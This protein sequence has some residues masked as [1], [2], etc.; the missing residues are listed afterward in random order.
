MNADPSLLVLDPARALAL[1]LPRLDGAVRRMT[2]RGLLALSGGTVSID[3][4]RRLAEAPRPAIFALTHH[5]AW[6]AVLAPAALIALRGGRRVRFLVDWM[7]VDLPWTG[8]LVRQIDPIRVDSKRALFGLRAPRRGSVRRAP[9]FDAALAA[10]RAGDDVGVY[11]E[12][13]RNRDPWRLGE[14]RRG[15][16]CLALRSGVPVVPVG[17]DFPAR[18]RILRT[19]RAGRFVLRVGEPLEFGAEH[20]RWL[21]ADGE[22]ERR[23]VEREA[24]GAIL[25]RVQREL[26]SLARKIFVAPA[27]ST[28]RSPAP[29]IEEPRRLVVERVDDADRRRA[30]LGVV[31]E[32]YQ[33]EKGWIPEAA[34]EIPDD[35]AA[36]SGV[37]WLLARLG[38]EPVGVVRVTYDPALAPPPEL[39]VELE[40]GVDLERLARSGRFAEVGRLM[41]RP[42]WRARPK[43]VLALMH[44]VGAEVIEHGVTHLVTAVF[45]DD[46]HSPYRFH[47]RQLGFERIGTHRRGELACASRRILLV[48]DIARSLERL[49]GRG[50]SVATGLGRGLGER[51][52]RPAAGAG[53]AGVAAT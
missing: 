8:W 10:L 51:L 43:I 9:A 18:D 12:G 3:G 11:P 47:T 31:A 46:P 41:I 42:E 50:T 7:F 5:N 53:G 4:A 2:L 1:E 14:G 21:E 27:R 28:P 36:E 6:E 39:G 23:S 20:A 44:A 33:A 13:R 29:R 26:A 17:V 34:T 37:T 49:A 38:E 25:D 16:A 40:P 24:A 30:A 48:L 32:V 45:E 15:V 22:T 35:P 52:A 19:P